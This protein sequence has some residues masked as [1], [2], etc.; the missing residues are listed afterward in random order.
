LAKQ[1][2]NQRA[3]GLSLGIICAA[4][5]IILSLWVI[6]MGTGQEWI[7]LT[8]AFYFGYST[9]I[10]GMLLGAIY[11][12]IDGFIGGWIFAWLYNKLA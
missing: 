7:N 2:L 10:V 12:F 11:G 1:K 3:F 8:A 9:T 5:M 4:A 6:L